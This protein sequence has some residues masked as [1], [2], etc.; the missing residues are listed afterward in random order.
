MN[1]QK[2]IEKMIKNER[3]NMN[4]AED[5]SFISQGRKET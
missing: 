4:K 1:P 3:D 2:L 5:M